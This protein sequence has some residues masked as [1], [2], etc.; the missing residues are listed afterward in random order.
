[1]VKK[2]PL[3]S[4]IVPTKN[5]AEFLDAC[6]R[7]I[8]DQTYKPTELIVVDNSSTDE[9]QLIAKRYTDKVYTKGPERSA[10]RNYGVRKCSGEYVLIIDSDMELEPTVV[11]ECVQCFMDIKVEGVVIPEESFGEGFWAQCKQLERSFYVGVDWI[12]AARGFRRK[13]YITLGGYDEALVS[14]EDWDLS[15]RAATKGETSRTRAFIHHNEGKLSLKKTLR[16][17]YYYAQK[18]KA[19]T[20]KAHVQTERQ[21]NVLARYALFFSKPQK[22]L[23]NPVQGLGMIAMKSA[24]YIAGALGMAGAVLTKNDQ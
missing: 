18:F 14:G 19:Y 17:K 3:V 15:Q 20:A 12:E 21:T 16:K 22:L 9:T 8:Q 4:V 13:T 10:Q 23:K 11:E 5:S 2:R 7:S 1:M 6:L 24:E